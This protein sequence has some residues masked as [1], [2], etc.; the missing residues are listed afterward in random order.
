MELVAGAVRGGIPLTRLSLR[1]CSLSKK[2]KQERETIHFVFFLKKILSPSTA[3]LELSS[4]LSVNSSPNE[5][6]SRLC[7]LVLVRFSIFG[8]KNFHFAVLSC[9]GAQF[10]AQRSL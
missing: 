7:E 9:A 6:D 4:S 1:N 2:G 5:R 8:A 3:L 10:A